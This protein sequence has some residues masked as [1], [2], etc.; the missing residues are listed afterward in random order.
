MHTVI[1][2]EGRT[3]LASTALTYDRGW[4]TMIFACTPSGDVTDWHELHVARY[5]NEEAAHLGHEDAVKRW[6]PK[7]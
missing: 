4:E 2:R 1:H 7:L 3:Y 5:P 6:N